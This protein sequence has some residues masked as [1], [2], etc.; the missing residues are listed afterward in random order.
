M[1]RSVSALDMRKGFTLV[2]VMV[3][4]LIISVVIMALLQMRGHSAHIFSSLS[5]KTKANA[6]L[7][8]MLSNDAYGFESQTLTADVLLGDFD[9]DDGLKEA[10]KQV[11]IELLYQELD[12]IELNEQE[13]DTLRSETVF[14]RGKTI[15]KTQN[16]SLFLPRMR[17]P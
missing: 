7:S 3:A 14:L 5:D 6:Y 15:L 2:E 16:A 8:F 10:L 12:P 13:G 11:R 4:V 17:L 9:L 1:K